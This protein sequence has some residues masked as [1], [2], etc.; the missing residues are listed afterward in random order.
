MAGEQAM[1]GTGTLMADFYQRWAGG[2]GELGKSEALRDA[3]LPSLLL[4]RKKVVAVAASRG[5]STEE[6]TATRAPG[7]YTHPFYWAPFTL[8]GNWQ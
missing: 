5:L 4:N 2:G 6:A 7:D 8:M 1:R 3:Q